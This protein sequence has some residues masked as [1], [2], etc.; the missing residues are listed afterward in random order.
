MSEEHPKHTHFGYSEVPWQEKQSRV[1]QV[2][3]SVARRYDLMND[4]MSLGQHRLWKDR[5]IKMLSPQEGETI[6]D[7]AGGTGDLTARILKKIRGRGEIILSDINFNMLKEGV[8]R[9][10][11]QGQL[12][13]HYGVLNAESLPFL[14]TSIDALMIGFGLRNVRDQQAALNEMYRVL[15]P[16]GRALILEFSKMS[17]PFAKCYDWYSFH[18]LPKL[19]ALVAKDAHSYQYLAESIRKHPPQEQLKTM[20]YQA[21]FDEVRYENLFGGMVAIHLAWKAS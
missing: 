13:L 8:K 15:K 4:L 19:G 6:L 18:I 9:F 17:G 7:L 1:N 20:L 16:G 3:D 12:G 5:A 10:D 2:F 21:G 11:Q 14:P